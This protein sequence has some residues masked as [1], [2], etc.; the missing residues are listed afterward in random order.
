MTQTD[1]VNPFNQNRDTA[2]ECININMIKLLK[3][4]IAFLRGELS[5]E[6]KSNK[7][8]IEVFLEQNSNSSEKM[9]RILA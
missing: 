6:L 4:E 3:D 7:K 8:V 2:Q 5:Q 1:R 9:L